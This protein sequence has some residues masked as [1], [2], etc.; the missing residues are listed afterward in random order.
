MTRAE[1]EADL[2]LCARV[3]PEMV[4]AVAVVAEAFSDEV[5]YPSEDELGKSVLPA[6][7]L[8]QFAAMLR[9]KRMTPAERVAWWQAVAGQP[10]SVI[11]RGSGD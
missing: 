2:E 3:F 8:R 10:N 7:A 11:K 5:S 1:A 9:S 4:E 6:D